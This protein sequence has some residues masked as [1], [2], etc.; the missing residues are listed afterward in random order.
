MS[1]S[2]SEFMQASPVT[3]FPSG[4]Q[5]ARK[6]NSLDKVFKAEKPDDSAERMERL[7]DM[8]RESKTGRQT[9]EFLEE[10]G[11]KLI[12]EPMDYYGYFSPDKNI[13]ALNPAFSDEDCAVTFVH[14]VRHAWQD[15]QMSK[16]GLESTTTPVMTPKSFFVS[17]YFIEADA[18]AA[19]VTYAHEMR[20]TNPK[21]WEAHQ[22]S[23]YAP[24]STAFEKKFKETGSVEEAR[25]EALLTWYGLKVQQ[26]YEKTYV[27]YIGQVAG[28][29]KQQRKL[30]PV[31][32]SEDRSTKLML[33][34][35][36]K[37]YDGKPFI[38]DPK[39]LEGPDNLY[40]SERGAKQMSRALAGYMVKYNRSSSDLGLDKISVHY[41]DGSKGTCKDIA[42]DT[43]LGGHTKNRDQ[44][45]A[46]YATLAQ[47]RQR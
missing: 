6:I 17:G 26:N 47:N 21:I 40:V 25:Q 35:M 19:E 38:T 16:N 13:V 15:T 14:E 11:A 41:A 31:Y 22:K 32:F 28:A 43:K 24:M 36:G 8:L 3:R 7:K 2:Y 4:I 23:G 46:I 5:Y 9:L 1:A 33:D 18:C 42:V 12:F 29:L 30:E 39:L 37:D 10:K 44:K 45:Q 27:D 34:L 20:E